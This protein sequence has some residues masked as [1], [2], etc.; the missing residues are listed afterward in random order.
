MPSYT[1]Q[2]L[3]GSLARSPR[4]GCCLS[5]G[6][7]AGIFNHRSRYIR[8]AVS[9]VDIVPPPSSVLLIRNPRRVRSTMRRVL[10]AVDRV[11]YLLAFLDDF[12]P[13]VIEIRDATIK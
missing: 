2:K 9:T 12:S 10:G 13:A 11:G 6:W 5:G 1:I 3:N 7:D 4:L 8:T